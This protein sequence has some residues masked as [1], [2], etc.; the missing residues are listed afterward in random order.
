MDRRPL[1]NAALE[2]YSNAPVA[3]TV[4]RSAIPSMLSMLL[5]LVYNLADTFFVGQTGD[6]IQVAA[7]TICMPAFLLFMAF[8]TVLGAGGASCISR[9]LGAGDQEKARHYSSFCFWTAWF[10]GVVGMLVFLLFTGPI[11]RGIGASAQTESH[12]RAYLRIVSFSAPFII[13]SN[14]FSN[15]VR[16]EGKPTV[17]VIGMIAGNIINIVLD[18]ILILTLKM[19]VAGAA[20]ATTIANVFSGVYYLVFLFRDRDVLSISPRH[21]TLRNRIPFDVLSIGL[22]SA[23]QSILM[24]VANVLVNNVLVA[25]SDYAVAAMGVAMRVDMITGMVMIGLAQGIMPAMG[26]N[27]GAGNYDRARKILRFAA[28]FALILGTTLTLLCWF[29][30]G[31][32]VRTFIN[33]AE[34]QELGVK[35]VHCLLI[36]GPIVGVGFLF[37]FALQALGAAKECLLLSVTRQG[38][39]YIPA[40]YLLNALFQLDGIAFALPVANFVAFFL[41]ILFFLRA[42]R[43]AKAA[44]TAA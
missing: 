35:F 4:F 7:V 44:R 17:A 40:L 14:A 22:P 11:L 29:G 6:P 28:I 13:L 1:N 18:P 23:L 8:G 9:S 39:A 37:T 20:L 21:F 38:L 27:Y 12:A 25:Y 19:G 42:E 5:V 41:S 3:R 36:A 31:A 26:F 15:I 2:L 10:L 33:A 24:S 32:I 43:K 16:A 30:A 34:V